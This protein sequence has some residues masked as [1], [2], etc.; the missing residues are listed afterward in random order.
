MKTYTFSENNSGGSWWLSRENYDALMEKGWKYEPSEYD[1]KQ[2][3]DTQSFMNSQTDNVP[4]GWRHGLT[5]EFESIREAVESF[6]LATG[7]DFFDQGCN[8]CGAPFS[9]SSRG[10]NDY[11][12]L[13]GDS[14]AHTPNRPW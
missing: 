4:Y 5:G 13:S 8:C 12:Y 1:I 11:E 6:E 10:D 2:N 3:H 7:K 14:V 9:I